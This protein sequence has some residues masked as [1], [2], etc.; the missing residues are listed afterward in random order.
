MPTRKS[1]FLPAKYGT[2]P[3]DPFPQR[4]VRS[5][6]DV[7]SV[8]DWP[9]SARGMEGWE[10]YLGTPFAE[11]GYGNPFRTPGGIHPKE[12]AFIQNATADAGTP[13]VQVFEDYSLGT[14]RSAVSERPSRSVVPARQAGPSH[15]TE[16]V[17]TYQTRLLAMRSNM[18]SH[19]STEAQERAYSMPFRTNRLTE[20][21]YEG[22]GGIGGDSYGVEL[23]GWS[24]KGAISERYTERSTPEYVLRHEYSHALEPTERTGRSSYNLASLTKR[25]QNDI[26]EYAPWVF[27][28]ISAGDPNWWRHA[29]TSL[30]QVP[31]RIPVPLRKY[32]PQYSEE[33]Y[34]VEQQDFGSSKGNTPFVRMK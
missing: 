20:N 17:D 30:G 11:E 1:R 26:T 21:N 9:S 27:A 2:E 12:Y 3:Q 8:A 6:I 32:F 13:K 19:Y 22:V 15:G 4:S 34:N 7:G 14:S 18:L 16:D 33:M 31:E 10:E 25:F 24:Q 28:D 5:G 29:Y 23:M